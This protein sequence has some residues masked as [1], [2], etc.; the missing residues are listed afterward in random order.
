MKDHFDELFKEFNKIKS[1]I[2][3]NWLEDCKPRIITAVQIP[4]QR[5]S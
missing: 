4:V 1:Y 2:M 5:T 3:K